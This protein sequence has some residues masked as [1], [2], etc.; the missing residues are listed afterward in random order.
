MTPDDEVEASL[1]EAYSRRL[2]SAFHLWAVQLGEEGSIS[3]EAAARLFASHGSFPA[4]SVWRSLML[5]NAEVEARKQEPKEFEGKASGQAPSPGNARLRAVQIL[6]GERTTREE[7]DR[8]VKAFPGRRLKGQDHKWNLTE[9]E[10][11][12]ALR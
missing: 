3:Q 6:G 5:H 9:D 1:R 12:E 10:L 11:A 2:A 4:Y 7:W 8:L